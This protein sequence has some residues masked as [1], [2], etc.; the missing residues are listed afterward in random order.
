MRVRNAHA[1]IMQIKQFM[2]DIFF[3]YSRVF[4]DHGRASEPAVVMATRGPRL[5]VAK[6]RQRFP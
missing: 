4:P 6:Q 1:L 3:L 2:F 5:S